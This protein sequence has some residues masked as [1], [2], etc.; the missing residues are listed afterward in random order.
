MPSERVADTLK[1]AN[2]ALSALIAE[3]E[4]V[5]IS[6]IEKRAGLSNGALNYK[7]DEYL[8][9]KSKVAKINENKKVEVT[10]KDIK[11]KESRDKERLL[12]EKYK[13]QRDEYKAM[14]KKEVQARLEVT[15]NLFHLQSEISDRNSEKIVNIS[16]YIE[17]DS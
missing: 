14:L 2:L 15:Y 11:L 8:E 16:G 4:R 10:P 5:S 9:F 7:I 12:K 6:A 1:A 17:S 3:G 13:S